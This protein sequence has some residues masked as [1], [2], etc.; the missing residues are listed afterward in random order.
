MARRLFV[1]VSLGALAL[2]GLGCSLIS[3]A[4]LGPVSPYCHCDDAHCPPGQ[5]GLLRSQC[6]LGGPAAG[7][8]EVCGAY[9][10]CA[11]GCFDGCGGGCQPIRGTL[12]AI[13]RFFHAE[14]WCGRSCGEAYWGGWVSDPPDC[15]DPCDQC[16]NW[17]GVAM[18]GCV[19]PACG[20]GAS[21][22][23]PAYPAESAP[24]STCPTCGG[25]TTLYG[26]RPRP[27]ARLVQAAQPAPAT[28]MQAPPAQAAIAPEPMAAGNPVAAPAQRV[29]RTISY[30]AA[31]RPAVQA[32]PRTVM[33]PSPA[34]PT[35][36][37][38]AAPRGSTGAWNGGVLGQAGRAVGVVGSPTQRVAVRPAGAVPRAGVG[39]AS[40]AGVIGQA[41][42]VPR[43]LSPHEFPDIIT[44]PSSPY[45]PKLISVDDRVVGEPVA[46][47]S[48]A[49]GAVEPSVPS[50]SAPGAPQWTAQRPAPAVRH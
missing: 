31:P 35:H 14:R 8:D 17:T 22:G 6:G 15:C 16:G 39:S 46:E 23:P 2:P 1:I 18:R 12:R 3:D 33:Q 28:D 9:D 19:A 42:P 41:P 45:A 24:A 30:P 50:R 34:Y 27:D 47:S 26:S 40:G 5:V 29:A 44:D 11:P 32:A 21:W 20:V 25:G 43:T 4:V 49:Q 48:V 37:G 10:T 13:Y 7:C 38:Y 36:R